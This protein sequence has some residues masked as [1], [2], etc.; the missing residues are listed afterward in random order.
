MPC[1]LI[2]LFKKLYSLV[3]IMLLSKIN[4]I[5]WK[6]L[7]WRWLK[8]LSILDKIFRNFCVII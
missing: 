4:M 6:V 1:F 7:G 3:N 5:K 8:H 2:L